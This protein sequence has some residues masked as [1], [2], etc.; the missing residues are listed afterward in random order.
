[1]PVRSSRLVVSVGPILLRG[2]LGLLG[3]CREQGLKADCEQDGS[4]GI[5]RLHLPPTP[6]R[7]F[8][9]TVLG[10]LSSRLTCK[11]AR[12]VHVGHLET[13]R[14][15]DGVVRANEVEIAAHG[16]SLRW[17]FGTGAIRLVHES[18]MLLSQV[19]RYRTRPSVQARNAQPDPRARLGNIFG[20][21]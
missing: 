8:R 5:S 2:S 16:L 7:D 21:R 15:G 10:H 9:D 4:G 20:S 14:V 18:V 11:R 6:V 12:L 19:V 1:M 17:A 3:L 13:F